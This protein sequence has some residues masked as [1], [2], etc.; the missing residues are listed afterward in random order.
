LFEA[1]DRRR[2]EIFAY[3]H[4][5]DDG[6]ALRSRVR[7][8]FPHWRELAGASDGAA[9]D[10]IRADDLDVLVELKGHTTG[11]RLPILAS[12]PARRQIHYL[13]YPGTIAY[14]AIDAI[15]ATRSSSAGRRRV[16]RRGGA[17][18]A[19]LLP[20]ERSRTCA[21]PAASS[22]RAGAARRRD[23]H[24]LLQPAGQAQPGVLGHLDGGAGGAPGRDAGRL[25]AA[26]VARAPSRGRG[27][28]RG[29][30]RRRVRTWAKA[31]PD[32]HVARLRCL[33]LAVDTLPCRRAHDRQ[34]CAVGGRA[35]ADVR[36]QHVRRPRGASLV[37]A[38]GIP[39]FAADSLPDYGRSSTRC[40]ATARASPTTGGASKRSATRSRYSTPADS[41]AHSRRC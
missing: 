18:P 22:R 33:D 34:R 12:R 25:C 30:R 8:A 23:R 20:G 10:A 7:A 35:A 4:G 17:A 16:V 19:A 31:P 29:A 13:G 38:A 40:C 9:A 27:A 3:S 6:S 41:R 28:R 21:S 1:H 11:S 32:V 14:P 5:P 37:A 39:E 2:V 26:A 24:R 36:R 15:V